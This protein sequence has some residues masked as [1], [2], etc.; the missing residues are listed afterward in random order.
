MKRLPIVAAGVLS[1]AIIPRDGWALGLGEL[2]LYSYLN[3]PFR[4][5][6]VLL[7]ADALDDNDV[8]VDLEVGA[9]PHLPTNPVKTKSK[10]RAQRLAQRLVAIMSHPR[11]K[12]VE[13]GHNQG[14][15][16]NKIA[17]TIPKTLGEL[18]MI[19]SR[20]LALGMQQGILR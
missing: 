12:I 4:A 9:Q 19:L 15:N 17:R 18:C 6:V 13:E 16:H 11:G 5:E 7:E 20:Y 3:E 10:I 1:A 2:T 8:H 14:R